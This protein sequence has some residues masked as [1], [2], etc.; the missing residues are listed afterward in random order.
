MSSIELRGG[1]TIR[2]RDSL[3]RAFFC[4]IKR[5]RIRSGS[6]PPSFGDFF[7]VYKRIP[8]VAI[9][10]VRHLRLCRKWDPL[11]PLPSH[12]IRRSSSSF[13]FPLSSKRRCINNARSL[14][15]HYL[16]KKVNSTLNEN[17]CD[18]MCNIFNLTFLKN[19]LWGKKS[20]INKLN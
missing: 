14:H 13:I 11:L 1:I 10:A 15:F 8:L 5:F 3:S 4:P 19:N 17:Y 12:S 20:K 7:I 9:H 18:V 16:R 6:R 2:Q